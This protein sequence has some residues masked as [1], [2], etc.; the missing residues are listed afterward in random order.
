LEA[1][2]HASDTHYGYGDSAAK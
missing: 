2:S 1:V